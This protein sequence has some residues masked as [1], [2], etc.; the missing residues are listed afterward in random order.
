VVLIAVVVGAIAATVHFT[1]QTPTPVATPPTG[2]APAEPGGK[3][4][5]RPDAPVTIEVYSDFL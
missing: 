3:T 2:P 1:S 5:G 4:R